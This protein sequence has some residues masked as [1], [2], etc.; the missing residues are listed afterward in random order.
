MSPNPYSMR[1]HSRPL[2]GSVTSLFPSRMLATLA[3]FFS[4][5]RLSLTQATATANIS[6]RASFSSC[7]LETWS[8]SSLGIP[9]FT[10]TETISLFRIL[11]SDCS[12]LKINIC[13][14]RP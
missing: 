6:H 2:T 11:P 5:I 14:S 1:T 8:N 9:I 12:L 4:L 10:C 13:V 7:H 3:V